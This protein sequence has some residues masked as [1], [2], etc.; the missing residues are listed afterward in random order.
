MPILKPGSK[1]PQCG[2][3]AK[4]LAP[5]PR[6]PHSGSMAPEEMAAKYSQEWIR[7][8]PSHEVRKSRFSIEEY[9]S[10]KM[11]GVFTAM[12]N[13]DEILRFNS[14][15]LIQGSEKGYINDQDHPNTVYSLCGNDL[16]TSKELCLS[17]GC[18]I[19]VELSKDALGVT[20]KIWDR[21]KDELCL[22]LETKNLQDACFK[23]LEFSEVT[24]GPRSLADPMISEDKDGTFIEN[25][26]LLKLY[27]EKIKLKI[28]N[29]KFIMG[30]AGPEASLSMFAKIL[31]SEVI[32]GPVIHFS[33]SQ[34]PGKLDSL[35]SE[36]SE[37]L[38]EGHFAQYYR[39]AIEG[40]KDIFNNTTIITPCNTAHASLEKWFAP[41]NSSLAIKDFRHS[42]VSHL[43][44]NSVDL[45]GILGTSATTHDYQIYQKYAGTCDSDMKFATSQSPDLIN[46]TIFM[47]K[48]GQSQHSLA[49]EI[50][51]A[52]IKK[53]R[54]ELGRNI[55]FALCCTE[56]PVVFTEEEIVSN[57]LICP[58][59]LVVKDLEASHHIM[60]PQPSPTAEAATSRKTLGT[61]QSKRL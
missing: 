57:R 29:A 45:V 49:K 31:Q 13:R 30:G 40:I 39:F 28:D 60:K 38:P 3:R 32:R 22:Y 47:I 16:E 61:S 11:I 5:N 4:E 35:H 59:S 41:S 12:N 53:I 55:P 19:L 20:Y 56:L 52:E 7:P 46:R 9:I 15:M 8:K 58:S 50:I 26:K 33:Y 34:T 43:Q 25:L 10:K 27:Q 1:A 21:E 48:H 36:K 14:Q 23:T 42:L 51:L 54:V 18:D 37:A 24:T 2:A 17:L 44:Q 6:T